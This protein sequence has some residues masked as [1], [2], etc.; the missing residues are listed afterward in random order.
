MKQK[1]SLTDL[2]TLLKP[3]L[4]QEAYP[5]LL[6]EIER[7]NLFNLCI[8]AD[9]ATMNRAIAVE[10]QERKRFL[11]AFGDELPESF[12]PQLDLL[13][14]K[15]NCVHEDEALLPKVS[16]VGLQLE[17]V[18]HLLDYLIERETNSAQ[19]SDVQSTTAQLASRKRDTGLPT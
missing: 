7:R 8:A 9:A 6:H 13:P 19:Y 1:K 12:I 3:Q 16:S 10:A 17:S 5:K 15:V 11:K 14:R 2:K 18:P 4:F